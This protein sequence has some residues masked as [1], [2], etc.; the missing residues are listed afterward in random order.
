MQKCATVHKEEG[1]MKE[2]RH[3]GFIGGGRI[4][5]ILVEALDRKDYDLSSIAFSESSGEAAAVLLG[6][7]PSLKQ[8]GQA[9]VAKRTR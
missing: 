7:F 4:V 8:L 5:R 3:I 6:D 2:E 9:E 1:F